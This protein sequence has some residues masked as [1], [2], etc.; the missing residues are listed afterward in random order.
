MGKVSETENV[1]KANVVNDRRSSYDRRNK[2]NRR[3]GKDR[4]EPKNRRSRWTFGHENIINMRSFKERRQAIERRIGPN[5][6]S[7]GIF[8]KYVRGFIIELLLFG[9][10]GLFLFFGF[11][12]MPVGGIFIGVSLIGLAIFL[13]FRSKDSR[14]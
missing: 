11:T 7:M 10:G 12:I 1:H 4:R 8:A 14:A 13:P 6:T 5:A 9:L 2:E 3:D